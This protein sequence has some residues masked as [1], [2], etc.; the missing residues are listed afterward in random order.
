MVDRPL[1]DGYF[2]LFMPMDYRL[3]TMD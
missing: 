2:F 1:S 3:L